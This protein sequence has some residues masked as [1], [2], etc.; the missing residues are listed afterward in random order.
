MNAGDPGELWLTTHAD[1]TGR[2]KILLAGA[3]LMVGARIAFVL[4]H[5]FLLLLIAA[6]VGVISPSGNEVGPFVSVE[7]AALSLS[8][9]PHSATDLL[10]CQPDT[11]AKPAGLAG[12]YGGC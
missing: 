2:R 5:N 6:T 8:D 11:P 1:R 10:P 4:T 12:Q 3:A 7:H 9:S